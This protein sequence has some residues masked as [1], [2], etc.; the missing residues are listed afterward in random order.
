ML[1]KLGELRI[2]GKP[3]QIFFGGDKHQICST[4]PR[5]KILGLRRREAVMVVE[6]DT[7]GYLSLPSL[8]EAVEDKHHDYCYA[9]YTGNYPTELVNIKE[10]MASKESRG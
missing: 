3:H 9:C 5:Q 1:R 6:A 7:L 8:R 10:L 4:R 2:A